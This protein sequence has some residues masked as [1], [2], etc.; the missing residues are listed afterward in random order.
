MSRR[1]LLS[2]LLLA[3]F[4]LVV[5]EIPLGLSYA[6][7]ERQE[8]T[9]K[10]ERDA[11]A[12]ATL[13]EDV[14]TGRGGIDRPT[15]ARTARR[16]Q[17]KT[18]GRVVIANAR[19]VVLVDTDPPERGTRTFASRPEFAEALENKI[20]SGSRHSEAL[21][22]DLLFV[23]VPVTTGGKVRGAVRVSQPT[24]A[25][26]ARVVR[27]WL[28]LAAIAVVV[29]LAAALVG[30]RLAGSIARP[31]RD[32]ERAAA[33]AGRG[34]LEARAPTDAGP[35]EIRSLAASFNDT[36]EKLEELIQSREEFAADAAHQLRTPLAALRL[37]LENLERDVAPAGYADLERALVEVGRLSS[38]VDGLLAL[39]R[40]GGAAAPKTIKLS[41]V[42]DERA[43]SWSS[44]VAE[45]EISFVADVDDTLLVRA[46]PGRL[47]QVLDNL[48]AN[49]VDVSPPHTWITVSAARA[50]DW[51]ELHVVDEGPGMSAEER[52]R[53]F[54]RLWQAGSGGGGSG[55]GLAI[56]H[57]LITS[58]GG[59]VELLPA[60]AGG[61]DAVVR[62]PAAA[63]GPGARRSLVRSRRVR[64]DVLA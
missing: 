32:V 31:L 63:G 53:A 60:R 11:A 46:T 52:A 35:A 44:L 57:R 10:L 49:A 30:R 61:I 48:V 9:R 25:I 14:L 50:G 56:V 23:A 36:V 24:S 7:S 26:A 58:D 20:A 16:Y 59:R 41:E 6:R 22:S 54:D 37:R 55:L 62:L 19:G 39:A 1:L 28:L 33:S 29:L 12:L 3:L 43:R 47:E 64:A 51:I 4:V 5:L 18:G 17:R 40:S 34:D 42:V 38:I 13:S 8:L 27:F 2:Y 21:E 15:L 45:Q